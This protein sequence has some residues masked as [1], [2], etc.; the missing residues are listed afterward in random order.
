MSSIIDKM[1]ILITS[2]GRSRRGLI[3]TSILWSSTCKP[4]CTSTFYEFETFLSRNLQISCNLCFRIRFYSFISVFCKNHN[5]QKPIA[6]ILPVGIC[7]SY[8][9]IIFITP[10]SYE[11]MQY[12]EAI[13]ELIKLFATI[14]YFL[15]QFKTM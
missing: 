12:S 5:Y 6:I 8:H 3:N 4:V 10:N 1:S 9:E 15:Q 2:L 13:L 11:L 14:R 7:S